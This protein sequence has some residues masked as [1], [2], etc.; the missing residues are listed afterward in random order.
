MS[1]ERKT[2]WEGIWK[3]ESVLR[4]HHLLCYVWTPMRFTHYRLIGISMVIERGNG[5]VL[6]T[7]AI[8]EADRIGFAISRGRIIFFQ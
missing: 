5:L 6:T 1:G 7:T 2:S 8:P 4:D 3:R